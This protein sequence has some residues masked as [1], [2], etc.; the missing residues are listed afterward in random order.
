MEYTTLYDIT[1]I[2]FYQLKVIKM[3]KNYDQ[4]V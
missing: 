1:G 2:N 4:S 3:M